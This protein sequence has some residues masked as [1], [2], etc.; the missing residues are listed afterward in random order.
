MRLVARSRATG[1]Y[2]PSTTRRFGLAALCSRAWYGCF[3]PSAL[4]PL[5]GIA[6]RGRGISVVV[7]LLA[8]PLPTLG[9]KAWSIAFADTLGKGIA[10]WLVAV[11]PSLPPP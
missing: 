2:A 6:L 1:A 8:L 3:V 10:A 7:A 5:S 9:V 11:V 4:A